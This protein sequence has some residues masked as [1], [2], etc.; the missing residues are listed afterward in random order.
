MLPTS[1]LGCAAG[2]AFQRGHLAPTVRQVRAALGD[3]ARERREEQSV[4]YTFSGRGLASTVD[5]VYPVHI[6]SP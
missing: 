6:E 1:G 3:W 4:K 2:L 5:T